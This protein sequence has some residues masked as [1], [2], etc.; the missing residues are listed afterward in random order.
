MQ[1]PCM[2]MCMLHRLH[3]V[4]IEHMCGSQSNSISCA[5]AAAIE[6]ISCGIG[7]KLTGLRHDDCSNQIAVGGISPRRAIGILSAAIAR[8]KSSADPTFCC[9]LEH[10]CLC[11]S[12]VYLMQVMQ[13]R[14]AAAMCHAE[15]W[16]RGSGQIQILIHAGNLT[17]TFPTKLPVRGLTE[18]DTLC[19]VA[20]QCQSMQWFRQDLDHILHNRRKKT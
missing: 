11:R 15:G 20:H 5:T 17:G 1:L 13:N 19:R 9:S 2:Q 14:T 4:N 16:I 8:P 7:S 10:L 18:A 6:T 12:L 3:Q